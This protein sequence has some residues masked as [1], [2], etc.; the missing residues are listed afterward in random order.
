MFTL[1]RFTLFS[2]LAVLLITSRAVR[3][4]VVRFKYLPID[5]A[6]NTQLVAKANGVT[7]ERAS[8]MGG[9][10]SPY[11]RRIE[12]THIV[13]YRLP[14]GQTVNVPITFPAG[15]PSVEHLPDRIVYNFSGYQITVRFLA[16]HS[17]EV[18]YNSGFLRPV[19]FQ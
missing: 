1:T 19:V 16:D 15:T 4:E 18:M 11:Y 6:G 13:T 2:A 7:G 12:P 10:W 9:A 14:G 5:P 3:A 8:W 17:V